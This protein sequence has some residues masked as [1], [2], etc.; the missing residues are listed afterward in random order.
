[1]NNRSFIPSDKIDE[2]LWETGEKENKYDTSN[3]KD[4]DLVKAIQGNFK[5]GIKI[6]GDRLIVFRED[7]RSNNESDNLYKIYGEIMKVLEFLADSFA[8]R[9]EI[10]EKANVNYWKDIPAEKKIEHT[11][12]V[13][14]NA[15]KIFKDSEEN[16][17][18]SEYEFFKAYDFLVSIRYL[19]DKVDAYLEI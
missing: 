17:E 6:D 11:N 18:L 9:Y 15:N 2:L 4:Q 5:W 16:H 3:F 10:V 8:E 1:M 12:K 13:K 7:N 19:G 14:E